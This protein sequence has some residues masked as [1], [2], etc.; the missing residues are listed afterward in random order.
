MRLRVALREVV[1]VVGRH[2][3]IRQFAGN[4]DELLVERIFFGHPVAHDL[5]VKAVAENLP[6]HLRVA[7]G[8]RVVVLEQRRRDHRR[9][10][11]RQHDQTLVVLREQIHIDARLV[12]VAVEETARD[13]RGEVL[14]ADVA[15]GEQRDV[16]FVADGTVEPAPRGNIGLAADDRRDARTSFWPCR[17]SRRRRT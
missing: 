17:R 9:H 11:A 5:D 8:G 12:V 3:R 6:E 4:A 10:A 16:R 1:R 2:D 14:V 7:L 15:R 13:Q